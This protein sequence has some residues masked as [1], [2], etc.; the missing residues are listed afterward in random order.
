M[1]IR[2]RMAKLEALSIILLFIHDWYLDNYE[3]K[4]PNA[5][6]IPHKLRRIHA[7]TKEINA[8]VHGG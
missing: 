7:A 4:K 8:I 6:D 5:G 3:H 1:T 2:I